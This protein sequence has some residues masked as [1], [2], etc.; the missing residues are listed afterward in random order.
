VP[1]RQNR[2]PWCDG[3]PPPSVS[4]PRQARA[5]HR[6]D[7]RRRRAPQPASLHASPGPHVRCRNSPE[8]FQPRRASPDATRSTSVYKARKSLARSYN[9]SRWTISRWTN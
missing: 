3:A 2:C 7:T 9:V 8:K 5:A 1:L 6:P 4:M